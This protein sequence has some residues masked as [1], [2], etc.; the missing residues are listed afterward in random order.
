[1]KKRHLSFAQRLAILSGAVLCMCQP[2]R[3]FDNSVSFVLAA[4]DNGFAEYDFKYERRIGSFGIGLNTGLFSYVFSK[5]QND[6]QSFYPIDY[7]PAVYVSYHVPVSEKTELKPELGIGYAYEGT[8]HPDDSL[9]TFE[10]SSFSGSDTLSYSNRARHFLIFSPRLNYVMNFNRVS[11]GLY[12]GVSESIW[13]NHT[14]EPDSFNKTAVLTTAPFF[15][16][17]CGINF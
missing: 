6:V 16:L 3:S 5:A 11:L 7:R 2:A 13:L 14:N 17:S 10:N 4:A 15:G 12:G 1:M 8:N 9:H